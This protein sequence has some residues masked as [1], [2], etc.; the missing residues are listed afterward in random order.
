MVKKKYKSKRLTLHKKYKIARKVREHKRQERKKERL[1][2]TK[3]KDPG[4]PNN[5]PFKEELLLQVEQARLAEL[6]AARLAQEKRKEERKKQ[7][8]LDRDQRNAL[9]SV[10]SVTPLSVEM[11]A[12]KD[13]KDTVTAADLVIV[14]LD[15]RDPQGTRS[16]SLEDGLIAKGGKK[17]LLV[18]NK[19]DLIAV[20]VAQKWVTYLRRFHPTIAVRSLNQKVVE[21][22]KKSRAN[23][24]Q[25][26]LYER[27]QGLDGLRDNG[28]VQTLRYFLDEYSNTAKS[29]LTVAVLGYPNVG[30][31]TLI[32]SLKKKLVSPV[33]ATPFSTK[34]AVEV[35]YND[36]IKLVDCPALDPDYS[37]PTAIIMRNGIAEQFN[38]DPVPAVQELLERADGTNLMQQLQIPIFKTHEDFLK[39]LA[40]KRNLLRKGGDPDV[41]LMARTF[42]KSLGNG[43]CDTC[44]LPP[45]KSKSRFEMPKWFQSLKLTKKM[46]ELETSLYTSNPSSQLKRVI[47]F[48]ACTAAHSAG[49]TTEYDLIMGELPECDGLTSDEEEEDGDEV[50]ED[51]EEEEMESDDE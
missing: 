33:S 39:K 20:D 45:T 49:E 12:K 22:K 51:G 14:V 48:K 28:N 27:T 41:L 42:L 44:C 6:E 3:K 30:K 32:N 21:V 26:A 36:K 38:E 4:I 25:Q 29:P 23:K 47:L 50:M 9:S 16:L 46:T 18:L 40:I 34:S 11:Q 17:V 8:Q 31:S 24:G 5:W 15:A 2:P 7:K 1:H 35:M 19:I 10:P 37:D 43:A 13:V